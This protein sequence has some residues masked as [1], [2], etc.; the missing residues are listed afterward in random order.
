MQ[1]LKKEETIEQ[2]DVPKQ[3]KFSGKCIVTLNSSE[4]AK[5]LITHYKLTWKESTIY[6]VQEL[7][8]L[9]SAYRKMYKGHII[10]LDRAADP[11]DL[12]FGNFGSHNI[13]RLKQRLMVTLI[14]ASLVS[15]TFIILTFGKKI[16]NESKVN[17][18]NPLVYSFLAS[19]SVAFFNS[20]LGRLVRYFSLDEFYSQQSL[21]Y[22]YVARR[23]TVV[24]LGNMLLTTFLANLASFY[25]IGQPSAST[26]PGI[27]LNMIGLMNDFFFIN[28]TNSFLA[29]TFTFLDYRYLF[30]MLKKWYTSKYKLVTQA[31]AN[32]CFE[33]QPIDMALKYSHAYRLLLFTAAV[34][35]C[36]PNALIISLGVIILVYFVDKYLI[37]RRLMCQ[38]KLGEALSMRMLKILNFYPVF[39]SL[40]NFL[41][42]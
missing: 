21:Y 42:M 16:F 13:V 11:S 33:N 35:P 19:L 10:K 4:S 9:D 18:R 14:I 41:I 2:I 20:I 32:M 31:E 37:L 34:A 22:Y 1:N 39:V 38:Y 23:V 28:A 7:L 15:L 26:Y 12:I 24:Y 8:K 40:T 3:V 27:S 36:I 25:L 30:R 29:I 6:R 17:S 5:A